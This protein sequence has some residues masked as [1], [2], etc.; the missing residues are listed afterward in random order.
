MKKIIPYLFF[1]SITISNTG[2]TT[3]RVQTGLS[4]GNRP[5]SNL[6]HVTRH[7]LFWG[8]VLNGI[9]VVP[10]SLCKSKKMQ[11]VLVKTNVWQ[12]IVTV[13]TLGIYC[14][15]E[16]WWNCAKADDREQP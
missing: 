16:I 3:L 6:P 7:R 5:D 2:C 15:V 10:D 13:A 12:S 9:L 1:V 14:P 4:Q 11:Q 8:Y